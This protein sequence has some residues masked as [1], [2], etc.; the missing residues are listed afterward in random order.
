MKNLLSIPICLRICSAIRV[1]SLLRFPIINIMHRKTPGNICR[2]T[3]RVGSFTQFPASESL[4]RAG[5]FRGCPQARQGRARQPST[6]AVP[7][8][9]EQGSWGSPSP[10]HQAPPG[11]RHRLTCPPATF[12]K[13]PQ[14][15]R[16]LWALPSPSLF[17]HSFLN[18]QTDP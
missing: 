8:P 16:S 9:R 1:K 13:S 7:Q 2:H 15:Q 6:I 17:L 3:V 5:D 12:R 18:G 10:R 4:L 14:E 11:Y